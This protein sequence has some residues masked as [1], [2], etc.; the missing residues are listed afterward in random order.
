MQKTNGGTRLCSQLSRMKHSH[1]PVPGP[2]RRKQVSTYPW[3]NH[4]LRGDWS[5]VL[6]R[7]QYNGMLLWS[8]ITNIKPGHII[9][10]KTGRHWNIPAH[11]KYILWHLNFYSQDASVQ[12]YSLCDDGADD[13]SWLVCGG[14]P[15]TCDNDTD[16]PRPSWWSCDYQLVQVRATVRI[17]CLV[18]SCLF[19]AYFVQCNLVT[20]LVQS[21]WIM[22]N[23]TKASDLIDQGCIGVQRHW[24]K[25]FE[26]SCELLRFDADKLLHFQSC[27]CG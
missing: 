9:H 15:V 18:F 5:L 8:Y 12:V 20:S 22:T 3:L 27:L 11:N 4:L 21:D 24:N 16:H 6:C 1:G 26:G 2:S 25:H 7:C 19:R 17:P 14:G 23:I 10:F 13:W